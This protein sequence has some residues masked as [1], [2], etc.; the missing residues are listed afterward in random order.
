MRLN[1]PF[2]ASFGA[3]EAAGV[4]RFAE[5]VLG[6]E[7]ALALFEAPSFALMRVT[8]VFSATRFLPK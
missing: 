6:F 1:I 3:F 5:D 7:G 4:I 2:F 8:F